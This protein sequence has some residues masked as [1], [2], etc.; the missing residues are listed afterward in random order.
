MDHH[1]FQ[2]PKEALEKLQDPHYIKKQMDE[3]KTFQEILGYSIE[4]MERFYEAAHVLFQKQQYEEASDAFIFLTVLNPGV[5][6]YW[7][8]LGMSEQLNEEYDAAL[9]AYNMAIATNSDNPLPHYHSASCYYAL[10][11]K[12]NARIALEAAIKCAD[13]GDLSIKSH[14][15]KALDRLDKD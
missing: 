2:I 10:H 12:H 8:G 9:M 15:E 1:E 14:A 13:E 6:N 5:H 11:D 7:L 4:T 3:G